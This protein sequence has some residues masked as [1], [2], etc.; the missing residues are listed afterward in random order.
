MSCTFKFHLL[1]LFENVW[2]SAYKFESYD[3]AIELM[4]RLRTKHSQ[5][6][7]ILP[8]IFWNGY[9]KMIIMMIMIKW[10]IE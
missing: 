4:V 3:T 8:V 10:I 7:S 5:N 1:G 6:V 9:L 2:D